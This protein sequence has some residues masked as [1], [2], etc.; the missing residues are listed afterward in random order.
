MAEA[1]GVRWNPLRDWVKA[2]DAR[3]RRK[4]GI[5]EFTSDPECILRIGSSKAPQEALLSDGT[6]VHK[7]EPIG[8]LHLSSERM[9]VIPASGADMTW[10][11][12]FARQ[13]M[14]SFHLLAEYVEQDRS[15]VGIRAFGGEVV[16]IF[17][18][19]ILRLFSRLG[20]EVVDSPTH[21]GVVG[22]IVD[23]AMRVWTWLLRWAF[24]PE[25]AH[26]LGVFD[27]RFIWLSVDRLI[28]I[29]GSGAGVVRGTLG[30]GSGT[31]TSTSSVPKDS[32]ERNPAAEVTGG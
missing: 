4:L 25:S 5:R 27:R 28:K 3:Q 24:N 11:R 23:T 14:Y 7:G 26:G 31:G 22:W 6:L 10:A 8:V 18:P 29:H 2:F 21:R 30:R 16:F 32:R 15:M 1:Q 9:L 13:L 17:S 19:P 20:I 12:A